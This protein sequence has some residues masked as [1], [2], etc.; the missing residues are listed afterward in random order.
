MLAIYDR[1][2]G[3]VTGSFENI[4]TIQC[5]VIQMMTCQI[6]RCRFYTR[7]SP[8]QTSKN[9]AACRV[10]PP[11]GV[12][13][14]LL[15]RPA[16]AGARKRKH[17]SDEGGGGAAGMYCN[18]RQVCRTL[19]L[20]LRASGPGYTTVQDNPLGRVLICLKL[21]RIIPSCSSVFDCGHAL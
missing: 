1:A 4:C 16:K 2:H 19:R 9:T 17:A 11:P 7:P 20:R 12:A 3:K 14:S 10:S 18:V 6:L 8:L 5:F 21:G 13:P 15:R